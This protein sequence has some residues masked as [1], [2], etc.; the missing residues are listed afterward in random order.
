MRLLPLLKK[1]AHCPSCLLPSSTFRAIGRREGGAGGRRLDA[2]AKKGSNNNA[3]RTH[4][5]SQRHTAARYRRYARAFIC[6]TPIP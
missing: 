6:G 4:S 3:T 5:S 1:P 2:R